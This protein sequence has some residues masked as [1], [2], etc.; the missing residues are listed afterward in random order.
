MFEKEIQNI[1]Q[2][3]LANALGKEQIQLTE[4]MRW[5]IPQSVK[6]YFNIFAERILIEEVLNLLYSKRFDQ[7]NPD[8]ISIRKKLIT[9][10][11]NSFLFTYP[12]FENA[13]DKASKFSL[14]F[15]IRPEW[16]LTK[17]I[18]KN[19]EVKT[20]EQIFDSL[21]NINEYPYYKKLITKIL[22]KYQPNE[23][24]VDFF[25]KMLR[26]I[27]E[28]VFKNVSLNEMLSTTEPVFKLFKFAND[29]NLVPAEALMI[30]FADKGLENV[31][32]EIELEKDLHGR[33]KF[34]ES[35]LEIILK[36][37]LKPPIAEEPTPIQV[38]SS[39]FDQKT[40]TTEIKLEEKLEDFEPIESKP[41][42]KIETKLP[43]LNTLLD[44]KSR[45]KFIKKIFKRDEEK[46]KDA[47]NKLNSIDN[48]KEASA[49]ID[50]I[51]ITYEIDPY[52]DE[53][54]EFTD[55]VYRRY[56][57]GMR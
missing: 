46:F 15:V 40:E 18:F 16:T 2:K 57:P 49:F 23:V 34:A 43:D 10:L 52:S 7:D 22:E 24:K 19:D 13:V 29:L 55:F 32:K 20:A 9:T 31:V 47:I 51:F 3:I 8:L 35:D 39:Y 1:K 11:K 25:K 48:W 14:N 12:E 33:T 41:V 50:S 37:V 6:D 44:Q 27:D 42:S 28:E 4:I 54:V 38:P 26:R 45:E 5:D 36:R 30:F 17:I 53:A 56:F 21:S